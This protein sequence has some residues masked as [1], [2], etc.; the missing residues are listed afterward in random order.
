MAEPKVYTRDK[1]PIVDLTM[2]PRQNFMTTQDYFSRDDFKHLR[3]DLEHLKETR[4]GQDALRHLKEG[5]DL[6]KGEKEIL[7]DTLGKF[8]NNV[9]AITAMETWVKSHGQQMPEDILISSRGR[10]L[11]QSELREAAAD[12]AKLEKEKLGTVAALK[13]INEG[14]AKPNS[15]VQFP[16]SSL[17]SAGMLDGAENTTGTADFLLKPEGKKFMAA[18]GL[19]IDKLAPALPAPANTPVRQSPAVSTPK[20]GGR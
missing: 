7:G 17:K 8:A 14:K 4:E 19:D 18:V 9:G 3:S 13:Q 10:P 20:P 1:E 16:L 12:L 5:K 2:G 11:F 15:F 6:T